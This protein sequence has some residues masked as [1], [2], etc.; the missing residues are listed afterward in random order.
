M[1][2]GLAHICFTAGDLDASEAFYRDKLGF[3]HG[4]D[5]VRDDGTRSGVYL[6]VGG[7]NFLELFEGSLGEPAEGRTYRHFCLEVDDLAGTVETLRSRGVEVSDPA[8]GT[9]RSLQA[10]LSDPDGNRIELHQYTA[11]SKQGPSLQ[12]E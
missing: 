9:D 1:I 7:R 2:K 4:F 12:G 5:F 10:W 3:A 11:E 8:R 6:H